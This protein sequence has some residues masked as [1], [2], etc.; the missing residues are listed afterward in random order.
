MQTAANFIDQALALGEQELIALEN[1]DVEGA[2]EIAGQRSWILS[3][4]WEARMGCDEAAYKERLHKVYDMQN[5]L[6]ELAEQ[7]RE[8][9]RFGILRSR[10]E[11][12]RLVGYRQ[13]L[14]HAV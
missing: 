4:A 8:E 13:A 3:Q 7:K 11:G 12:R 9:L 1:G 2:M 6:T 10:Q 14:T 5:S